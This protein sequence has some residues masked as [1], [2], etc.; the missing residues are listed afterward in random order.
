MAISFTGDTSQV[1]SDLRIGITGVGTGLVNGGSELD[2][3]TTSGS[4]NNSSLVLGEGAGSDGTLTVTGTGS[5]VNMT[6]QSNFGDVRLDVGRSGTGELNIAAGGSI[7]G[8]GNNL[9]SNSSNIDSVINVGLNAGSFGAI[10]IDGG[11][12]TSSMEFLAGGSNSFEIANNGGAGTVSLENNA[13]LQLVAGASMDFAVGSSGAGTGILHLS[14]SSSVAA[15]SDDGDTRF[16]IGR[17][18]STGA[19]TLDGSLFQ[20]GSSGVTT[21][22]M[23]RNGGDAI[24]E[25]KSGSNFTMYSDDFGNGTNGANPGTKFDWGYNQGKASIT[26]DASQFNIQSFIGD[27]SGTLGY[28]DIGGTV[29]SQTEATL[30]ISNQAFFLIESGLDFDAELRIADGFMTE[31]TL[32][33]TDSSFTIMNLS[34]VRGDASL[35]VGADGGEASVNLDNADVRIGSG[36]S[37]VKMGLSNSFTGAVASMVLQNGTTFDL[38]GETAFFEV[39]VDGGTSSHLQVLSG[40]KI[41]IDGFGSMPSTD[42]YVGVLLVGMAENLNRALVEIVGTDSEIEV[43][44][45]VQIGFNVDDPNNAGMVGGGELQIR[46]GGTLSSG[47][48]F[49]G[50]GGV[51]IAGDATIILDQFAPEG[52]TFFVQE[53]QLSLLDNG[54]L[55][56]NGNLYIGDDN[57][58]D[59]DIAPDGSSAG[60]LVHNGSVLDLDGDGGPSSTLN[61]L[62]QGGYSFQQG[63][64]YVLI[65]SNASTADLV[66]PIDPTKVIVDSQDAEFGFM[67]NELQGALQTLTFTALNNGNGTGVSTVDFGA[68]STIGATFT[69][70]TSALA[71]SGSGGDLGSVLAFNADAVAGTSAADT[72]IVIGSGGV[73]LE[74]RDGSDSLTGGNGGDTLIG[75][76]GNDELNGGLGIDSILGGSGVDTVRG[77]GG[78]DTIELGGAS[79]FAFGQGGNDLVR[80]GGGID[81]ISGGSGADE[82]HGD[83]GN[84]I[85]DSD[86][87]GDTVFGGLGNDTIFGGNGG[88]TLNGDA[89][90]DTINGEGF[91]D[92][93]RGGDDNDTISGGGGIDNLFGDADDDMLFGNNGGD[94]LDGGTGNDELNG[95]AAN[96]ELR[97]GIGDDML[98][99]STGDDRLY[100]DVNRLDKWNFRSRSA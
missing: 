99:G 55:T 69:L 97:G 35:V 93:I 41:T 83:G 36:N 67:L 51:M 90:D 98:L 10:N 42:P 3:A 47:D 18:G 92:T 1:N 73:T 11:T 37:S 46:E 58:I 80:G 13:L 26:V 40:S 81:T 44:D 56:V 48:V 31:A 96:D 32:N 25:V 76:D 86:S 53:A 34:P 87:A 52:G 21:S 72:F 27:V 62:P 15:T 50:R 63:D 88:D 7:F 4:P 22:T 16:D 74:G 23:G 45:G 89:G 78:N 79:D 19:M 2:L 5:R 49:L 61:I 59:F 95:G 66:L 54:P 43:N 12:S 94:F 30:T 100:G 71:S 68:S 38:D 91:S 75:G 65:E 57:D 14:E 17:D 82:I 6:T 84:D 20:A 28:N 8:A 39:G 64:S 29:T 85:I 24:L 9:N 33:V 70:D 60:K 77:G